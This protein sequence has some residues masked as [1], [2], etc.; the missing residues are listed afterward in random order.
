MPNLFKTETESV[1]GGKLS[2]LAWEVLAFTAFKTACTLSGLSGSSKLPRTFVR[3]VF[4]LSRK[5]LPD[6]RTEFT[7]MSFC[8][9][10][11]PIMSGR[12]RHKV[13]PNIADNWFDALKSNVLPA[14]L[15]NVDCVLQ[16]VIRDK[17]AQACAL[18]FGMTRRMLNEAAHLEFSLQ[19][20]A[21]AKFDEDSPSDLEKLPTI[22]R[23]MVKDGVDAQRLEDAIKASVKALGKRPRTGY[24]TP[25]VAVKQ[26]GVSNS[27][28]ARIAVYASELR[29]RLID[30]DFKDY[31]DLILHF[32]SIFAI[33][34]N[35]FAS[36]QRLLLLRR[37]QEATC[38]MASLREPIHAY[39]AGP[40]MIPLCSVLRKGAAGPA[41]VDDD[42]VVEQ[43][44]DDESD[45][46]DK[47]LLQ[48]AD[49]PPANKKQK[50]DQYT[51]LLD[52]IEVASS[53]RLSAHRQA[54]ATCQVMVK[55]LLGSY[56][57]DICGE[58]CGCSLASIV[59]FDV[60]ESSICEVQRKLCRPKKRKSKKPL[61]K[62]HF[63]VTHD[64]EVRR[65]R[66]AAIKW[67]KTKHPYVRKR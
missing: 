55:L 29:N 42:P 1:P 7:V 46:D 5:S 23:G 54:V 10:F 18:A 63:L 26:S 24:L 17:N 15:S 34:A 16:Y 3:R 59:D 49:A 64:V 33:A 14:K 53:Y 40:G 52:N 41:D 56:F 4:S 57:L 8:K 28:A 22:L 13:K 45:D 51:K 6:S 20:Y 43:G 50:M 61:T 44:L 25:P 27:K 9:T 11:L 30:H 66:S 21:S 37:L 38:G 2:S 67:T 12:I 39:C 47:D 65:A 58:M 36:Y 62:C 32:E 48:H 35:R 31:Y 19:R 60:M